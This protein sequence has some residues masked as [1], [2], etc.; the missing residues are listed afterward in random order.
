MLDCLPLEIVYQILAH[1]PYSEFPI[2]HKALPEHLVEMALLG[3]LKQQQHSQ[4]EESLLKLVST[5]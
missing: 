1:V 3:K 4:Q 2:L 5:N